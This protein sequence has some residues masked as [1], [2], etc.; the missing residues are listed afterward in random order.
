MAMASSIWRSSTTIA[1]TSPSSLET[2]TAPLAPQPILRPATARRVLLI[3]D[4]NGDG[5]TDLGHRQSLSTIRW[6]LLLGNGNG[7]FQAPLT[8]TVGGTARN[9]ELSP[10]I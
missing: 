8:Y 1:A 3:A 6:S 10:K 2:V 9:G 7:T 4:F 5:W